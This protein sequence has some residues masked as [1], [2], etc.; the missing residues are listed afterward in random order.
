MFPCL[1]LPCRYCIPIIT[2]FVLFCLISSAI[3]QWAT[4]TFSALLSCWDLVT[5]SQHVF[6]DQPW[7]NIL[8]QYVQCQQSLVGYVPSVAAVNG[9]FVPG[10]L[11]F[12][13]PTRS[14]FWYFL[15]KPMKSLLVLSQAPLCLSLF[16][17][18]AFIHLSENTLGGTK[19]F[20]KKSYT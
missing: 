18:H 5:P 12:L 15:F 7:A 1:S 6:L 8:F 16:L 19:L 10:L 3:Y 17:E 13:N 20:L 2:H 4:G 11:S 9:A 14:L